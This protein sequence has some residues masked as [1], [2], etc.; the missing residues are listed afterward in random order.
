MNTRPWTASKLEFDDLTV[1]GYSVA[2]EE[3]VILVPE[4]NVCFDIGRCPRE[5]L[6]IDHVLLSH[7]H[8]DHSVGLLYYFAQRDFQGIAGGKAL[9]PSN[10]VEPIETLL[11][12]WGRVEGQVPPHEIIGR[13]AGQDYEL[14]RN[15]FARPFRVPHVPGALGYSI[16]DVRHKLKPELLGKE[17]PE[18]VTLKQQGMEITDRTEVPLVA[19]L[20]DTG[21]GDYTDN[22]AVRDARILLIEC[23]FFDD[24]HK[25]RA[26]A[27]RHIHIDA[28][29][30]ILERMNNQHIVIT[31][32][33]R[34]THLG[35]A[36]RRLR[37]TLPK[38][39]AEKVTFLMNRRN[40][41]D[42]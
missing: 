33:T 4:L 9:V 3:T 20:G 12:A 7:G 41:T 35:Q 11:R 30:G 25:S 6:P 18:L 38:A 29:P 14:R 13:K 1:I 31:H 8:A 28:L 42:E 22:P 36:R 24:E 39:V 26:K 27:G 10:L 16:I 21:P 19:Y 17:G 15:L 32:V 2:G 37:K 34:R 40:Q 5:A 23:T